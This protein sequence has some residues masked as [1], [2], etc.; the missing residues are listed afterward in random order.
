MDFMRRLAACVKVKHLRKRDKTYESNDFVRRKYRL[1]FSE[2]GDG[3]T[4]GS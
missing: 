1:C 4:L 3:S 2:Y